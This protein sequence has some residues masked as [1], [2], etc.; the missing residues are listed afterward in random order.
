MLTLA[1]SDGDLPLQPAVRNAVMEEESGDGRAV[2]HPHD[3]RGWGLF[4]EGDDFRLKIVEL[5]MH[6]IHHSTAGGSRKLYLA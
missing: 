6:D 2:Q 1:A 4:E 5:P 3:H